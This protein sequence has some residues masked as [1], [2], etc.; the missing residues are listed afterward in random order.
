[1]GLGLYIVNEILKLHHFVFDYK[2]QD[3][4]NLFIIATKGDKNGSY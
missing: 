1:M 4:K 3:G 2:H